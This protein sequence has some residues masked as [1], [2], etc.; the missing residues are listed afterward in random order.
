MPQAASA[1][2]GPAMPPG[3]HSARNTASVQDGMHTRVRRGNRAVAIWLFIMCALVAGMV[4]LGGATRLTGS[5]LSITEWK[6][7]TG[8]L[9]PL[10]E[11]AWQ[12]AMDRYRMIPE[13]R[14]INAG[15]SLDAFKTIYRWEWAHRLAGR[16]TGLAFLLPML[17]FIV[18]RRVSRSLACGLAGLFLLGG[19]QGLAGWYMVQSGLSVRVDVSQYRLAVHLSLALV[20]FALMFRLALGL[21]PGT[22][23]TDVPRALYMLSLFIVA[24]IFVQM[25]LGAFVAGLHA[26]KTF[27]T[28]PLMDGRFF[29]AGYFMHPPAWKDLFESVAAVQFNHRTGGL[30]LT[31]AAIW[32]YVVARKTA[33][34]P[35]VRLVLV[36]V[37]LQMALGIATVLTVTPVSLALLH[38][39]GALAVFAAALYASAGMSAGATGKK[40][41]IKPV[42][43]RS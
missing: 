36:C 20:L 34:A 43:C 18:T 37:L 2:S 4:V 11:Q 33:A 41:E 30:L 24:G 26:G 23:R 39:A 13:Y 10:S 8:I 15:M 5:G 32:Y 19:I 31:L 25:V 3:G 17:Y 14:E 42:L 21:W 1:T 40:P 6:P 29:P 27:N 16:I 22:R 9:P 28:W 38:Q 7:V 12:A 35:A